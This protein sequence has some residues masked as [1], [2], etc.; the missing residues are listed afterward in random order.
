LSGLAPLISLIAG[1][2]HTRSLSFF[3][4]KN[5][6]EKN[7][8]FAGVLVPFFFAV[9]SNYFSRNDKSLVYVDKFKFLMIIILLSIGILYFLLGSKK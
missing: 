2:F 4:Y 8:R 3:G 6:T 1:R 7:I 9:K 5:E